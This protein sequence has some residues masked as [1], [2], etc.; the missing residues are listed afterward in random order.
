M[1]KRQ[2]SGL[3]LYRRKD[4]GRWHI[5]GTAF[6]KK[7]RRSTKTYSREIA[8]VILSGVLEQEKKR[9]LFGDSVAPDFNTLAEKYLAES[10]KATILEDARYIE[11]MMP[12]IGTIPFNNIYRGMDAEG[13]PTPLE[14]YVLDRV[15]EGKRPRRELK[16][17]EKVEFKP[18]SARTLNYALGV[19][20]AIGNLA[21]KR[22]RNDKGAPMLAAWAPVQ[23]IS[24]EE[25][26]ALGL[27][28]VKE[29]YPISWDEQTVWMNEMVEHIRRPFYFALN[30]GLR[31]ANLE[32]LRWG[33]ERP[34]PE[35]GVSVFLIPAGYTKTK[36]A[37]WVILNSVAREIIRQCR[38]DHPEFVFA[39]KGKAPITI[40]GTGFKGS[41]TR[42][43]LKMPGLEK[44]TF[45]S[46]RHTFSARLRAAGVSKEDRD[47][48]MGHRGQ[49]MAEHYSAP[50]LLRMVELVERIVEP[51]KLVL[52]RTASGD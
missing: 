14:R 23:R 9:F 49:T 2:R 28:G 36:R 42:A 50:D 15:K 26:R 41:R 17:G 11:E 24:K 30:T 25:A 22:W 51:T 3:Y 52:I 13:T 21:A 16:P 37:H 5:G 34:V 48:L 27:A 35:I 38:G 7:I 29:P 39:C 32:Q 6:G 19:I 33:W 10:T 31:E 45:H 46:T 47:F 18:L 12:Y 43:A 8:E 20:N 44:A 40:H 1:R 4:G